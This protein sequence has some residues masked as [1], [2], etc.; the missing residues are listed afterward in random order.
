MFVFNQ[1]IVLC[2]LYAHS[3]HHHR[4]IETQSGFVSGCNEQSNQYYFNSRVDCVGRQYGCR[5]ECRKKVLVFHNFFCCWEKNKIDCCSTSRRSS[6][7]RRVIHKVTKEF[8]CQLIFQC[9][10]CKWNV[11]WASDNKLQTAAVV[12]QLPKHANQD[13]KFIEAAKKKKIY[14]KKT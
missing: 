7:R 12:V 6:V 13:L 10:W 5:S 8:F 14:L 1:F 2:L 9:T 11:N 3:L 4:Y